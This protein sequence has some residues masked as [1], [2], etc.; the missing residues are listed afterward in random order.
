MYDICSLYVSIYFDSGTLQRSLGIFQVAGRTTTRFSELRACS[1]TVNLLVFQVRV[2][3]ATFKLDSLVGSQGF[4]LKIQ[5][6]PVDLA[7]EIHQSSSRITGR[8]C[9]RPVIK[10]IEVA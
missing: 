4:A 7:M 9:E 5:N 1:F 8:S 2:R 3:L 10:F 6:E